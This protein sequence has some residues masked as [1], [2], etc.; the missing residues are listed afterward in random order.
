MAAIRMSQDASF[1]HLPRVELRSNAD[2]AREGREENV[3]VRTTSRRRPPTRTGTAPVPAAKVAARPC[4]HGRDSVLVLAGAGVAFG[5]LPL[6]G[7]P[8]LAWWV[9]G[10]GLVLAVVVALR[11]DLMRRRHELED[12]LLEAL[13]P[14]LGVRHLDRRIVRLGRWSRGWPGSPTKIRVYYAPGA[15]DGES[16]WKGEVLAVVAGRLLAPYEVAK[17]DRRKCTLWLRLVSDDENA[18]DPPY[19][20]IRAERAITELIG[21]TTKVTGVEMD[22]EELRSITVSHQAGA[23]LAASGYRTRIE[24]VISTMMPGRWRAV[25]DLE[26]DS[27]RFEVRPS[28]PASVWLPAR[29][30][31]ASDD[32]LKN[33]REVKIPCA[34]DED[35]REVLWY[36]ARVPQAMLTGGTGTGKTSMAHALLGQIT[37]YGWP[38]WVLDAKRVEFL[39]LRTWPNVQIVAGSVPQQV[40]LVHAAW[41]LMEYRYQLI[42]DGKATVNDFEPLVVFLDEFAEFRS[43]LL[44]WYA[45]IK[46]R[47]EP[48]KPPTLAEVASLAR[49][50]RTAR[51]HLVLSTQRPDAEFLGGEMRDNFG[52]RMSMGRLSPQGAMMMWENPAVGVALP[53]SCTGRATATHEDGKPVEVQCYRFPDLHPQAGSEEE[54]LLEQIRPDEERWPR[55]VIVPPDPPTDADGNRLMDSNGP[56]PLT[57]RDYAQARWDL[58]ENRPDLDPLATTE[59]EQDRPDGRELA[60][61]LAAL[62]IRTPQGAGATRLRDVTSPRYME[63]SE[64]PA[65]VTAEL[66]EDLDEYAGYAQPTNTGPHGLMVGD[67]IEVEDGTGIW[68]VVDEPPED[69]PVAPGMVAVSWR[70]DGDESGSISLPEDTQIQVRRPEEEGEPT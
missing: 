64:Q 59:A 50:A 55:L 43:N 39:D 20:Q 42:E 10:I 29:R 34:V 53:R 69:D 11:G 57:F 40:A 24:R 38:V 19:C 27:V 60:S 54:R 16:T 13:A 46:Q 56:V 45:Q 65:A 28:L 8:S 3:T 67:L 5:V 58:A 4:T 12:R 70:G 6:V 7:Y 21:P 15:A 37:Q 48:A 66:G 36:P 33:Y 52:F 2:H 68:V 44:E 18:A 1:L 51:I 63:P 49:K 25:W 61:T 23:K 26:G 14:L 32:L 9:L 30:P 22:G 31:E 47:G 62:G 41:E 35:G 17:H